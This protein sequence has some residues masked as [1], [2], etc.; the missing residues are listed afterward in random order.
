MQHR[1]IPALAAGLSSSVFAGLAA[2]GGPIFVDASLPAGSGD[3][4]SWATAFGGELGVQS[5]LSAATSGDEIWVADGAYVPTSGTNRNVSFVMKAG[6]ALYG[7]FEGGEASLDDRDPAMFPAILSGDLNGDDLGGPGPENSLHVVTATGGAITNA[8]RLDGFVVSG[9]NADGG[10][11]PSDRGGG[12]LFLNGADPLVSN[13]VVENNRCNFGG[14]AGYVRN[15]A[16]RFENTTFQNNSGGNFGGAF[17]LFNSSGTNVIR[18]IN[19]RV[20]N[21]RAGRAGGLEAFGGG[22]TMELVNCLVAGNTT[23]GGDAGGV[24]AAQGAVLR[25]DNSTIAGNSSSNGGGIFVTGGGHTVDNSIVWGNSPNSVNTQTGIVISWSIVDGGWGGPGTNN[26]DADPRLVNPAGGDPSFLAGSPAADAGNNTRVPAGTMVDLLG[27]PRF[28]DDGCSADTGLPGGL[29]GDVIADIGAFERVN[30]P[31]DCDGSGQPDEC[32]IAEGI[33]ADCDRNGIPDV[34][35]IAGGADDCNNNGIVD[36]CEVSQVVDV[37]S[38]TLSP[39]G[40]GTVQSFTLANAG[41][42]AADVLIS[43]IGRGDF[44]LA[45]ERVAVTVNGTNVGTIFTVGGNC[46]DPADEDELAIPAATWNDLVPAG[47][48][49]VIG[50]S[51]NGAVDPADC[52]NGSFIEAVVTYV[53]AGSND[54]DL[55]GVPD[56]CTSAPCP[57]DINMS[58]TVDTGDLLSVLAGWGACPKGKDCPADIDN[59]GDVAVGDL[60]AVLAGWGPCPG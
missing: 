14:G 20:L 26:L 40:G 6:V 3:G 48:N 21:N 2:A 9:G 32:E 59:S 19:C 34:C 24:F 13:C 36:S 44:D 35:D 56:D 11:D 10:T 38:G 60:L 58:G 15:S 42:A 25:M 12:L 46:S 43:A 55:D 27:N 7:G 8:S 23:T 1:I 16:P 39:I 17:D 49:A 53:T 29:G 18:F 45:F 50:F 28:T 5:A 4:T 30:D 22:L 51:G 54:A 33:L 41:E 52:N 31:A 57:A 47:S 37:E